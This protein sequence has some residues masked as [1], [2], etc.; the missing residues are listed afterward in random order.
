MAKKI[1]LKDKISLMNKCRAEEI[2][3]I[4]KIGKSAIGKTDYI[5]FLSGKYLSAKQRSQAMCYQCM[6]YYVDGRFDCGNYLC[7]NYT[8]M[9]YA[10][11]DKDPEDTE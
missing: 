8:L 3:I 5:N 4:E 7:P 10:K 1:T 2:K 9:P 6:G 11:Y